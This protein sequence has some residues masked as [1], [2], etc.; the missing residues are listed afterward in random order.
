M[1]EESIVPTRRGV[2]AVI[3]DGQ[4]LLVIRRSRHVVAP[5]AICFPGG[6]IEA[7]ETEPQALVRELDEELGSVVEP[8]RC[9]WRSVTA[10]RVELAWWLAR[11]APPVEI[12][13]N[14]AEVESI[15]WL[16]ASQLLLVPE[17]LASNRDF[18]AAVIDGRIP[19]P[20]HA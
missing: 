12:K 5:L 17:L 10:W 4:R 8:V 11:L 1:T 14:P 15:D 13:P 3:P 20:A 18:L 19:I 16:T 9:L 6:G 2:V 7:G